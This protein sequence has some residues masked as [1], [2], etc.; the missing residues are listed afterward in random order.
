MGEVTV[1][2]LTDKAG[3]IDQLAGAI[4]DI[5]ERKLAEQKSEACGHRLQVLSRRLVEVQEAER[6]HIARELHDEI[7]QALTAAQMNLQTVLQSPCTDATR[8][9][10]TES[11]AEVESVMEQVRDLSLDL[12]P[13][14]LDDLGLEPALRWFTNRQAAL[15]GLQ[16]RFVADASEHRFDPMIETECF[17]IAQEA[18]TNVVRHA[19]A[20]NVTVE[21]HT[22]NG[23]LDLDVRDD[24]VGF[25]V[26]RI[27]EQAVRGASLG[28]LSMEERATLAGGWLEFK[29]A[30]G[31]GT[32][33]HAWFP[34][35]SRIPDKN[36]SS[37]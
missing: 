36:E 4:R 8:L 10:L 25:D 33:V 27:R 24:G 21:L 13:S 2:P 23:H 37:R 29:S 14:M 19:H 26:A 12:R 17:R 3:R 15:A 18:L 30:P 5:T 34:L 1:T 11:V 9:R 22:K 16:A 28:V 20:H 35:K 6:R 32:D 31:Q 7:G